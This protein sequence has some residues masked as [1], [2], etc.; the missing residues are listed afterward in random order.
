M[1][2]VKYPKRLPAYE[3]EEGMQRLEALARKWGVSK[4]E[5]IRRALAE[6]ADREGVK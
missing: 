3:T 1:T 5:A 2:N 4:A 6:A